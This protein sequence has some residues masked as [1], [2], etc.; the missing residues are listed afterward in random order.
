[1]LD[2]HIWNLPCKWQARLFIL[3][4]LKVVSVII[5]ALVAG[6]RVLY[7]SPSQ[8][9]QKKKKKKKM[10]TEK[11]FAFPFQGPPAV[12]QGKLVTMSCMAVARIRCPGAQRHAD[13][14]E[15]D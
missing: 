6:D 10:T 3:F 5:T 14:V 11:F 4:P 2:C 1:M 7:I 13:K 8:P 15:V 9:P 12:A